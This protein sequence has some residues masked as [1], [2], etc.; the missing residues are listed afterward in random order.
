MLK[1][2]SEKNEIEYPLLSDEGSKLIDAFGI[3]N[4]MMAGKTYGKNDLTGVP[5]PG[6]YVL[7][8]DGKILAKLFLQK[9]QERHSTEEL[10]KLVEDATK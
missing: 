8:K 4:K 7:D 1:S 10:V 3:R 9:Y 6:S 5:H 2:F